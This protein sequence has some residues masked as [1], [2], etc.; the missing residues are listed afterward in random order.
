MDVLW[1][2][3]VM[4]KKRARSRT[5]RW[6][7]PTCGAVEE[8]S[9]DPIELAQ[10]GAPKCCECDREMGPCDTDLQPVLDALSRCALVLFRITEGDQQAFGNA[11][12][13]VQ[14]GVK[15]LQEYGEQNEWMGEIP[16]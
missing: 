14:A 7:C 15:L 12:E 16:A 3:Q 1:K 6:R 2:E 4:A 11:V 9:N 10:T 13:V 5:M 8:T